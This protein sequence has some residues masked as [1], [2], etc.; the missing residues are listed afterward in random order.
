[1]GAG[2]GATV[3]KPTDA[4]PGNRAVL[5]TPVDDGVNIGI[6]DLTVDGNRARDV[7]GED[8]GINFKG[9]LNIR[10]IN[11]EVRECGQDGIDFD[12]ADEVLVI[13]CWLHDNWGNG[14]HFAGGSQ[15]NSL[16]T[17]CVFEGNAF[18]RILDP[19]PEVALTAGGIDVQ[20]GFQITITN[21]VFRDNAR[22][23]VFS[24]GWAVMTGCIL[25][26]Y[27]TTQTCAMYCHGAASIVTVSGCEITSNTSPAIII[28]DAHASLTLN[29]CA[30]FSNTQAAILGTSTK[31]LTVNGGRIGT[32]LHGIHLLNQNSTPV[33]IT[34]VHFGSTSSGNHI[35][36]ETAGGGI[37]SGNFFTG[38]GTGVIDLRASAGGWLV[39]GNRSPSSTQFVRFFGTLATSNSVTNNYAAGS[40]V[41]QS[42]NNIVSGNRV[43]TIHCDGAGVTGNRIENN[44]ITTSVT[45]TGATYSSNTWRG[46]YGAG[47]AG[48]FAGTVTL[49]GGEG[50]IESA[51]I[52]ANSQVSITL[53]TVGG[54]I[55][56]QPYVNTITPGT[57]LTLAGGGASNT[58]VYNWSL[59]D[60]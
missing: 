16:V 53:K 52:S 55:G 4:T 12:S 21:S 6:R 30:I 33:K 38:G 34:G 17:G 46:N 48:V 60:S 24:E 5:A 27:S 22:E 1:V 7:Y 58:S 44:Q 10:I 47:V 3:I 57:S 28:E 31:V 15:G 36:V 19:I 35:R 41:L 50:T 37:I 14:I 13:G 9:G 32:N 45:N 26:H 8:E 39:D 20:Q 2:I 23:V 59:F 11:V 42:A 56:G 40:I 43:T 49:T 25:R 51:A 54:T 18:G 29:G